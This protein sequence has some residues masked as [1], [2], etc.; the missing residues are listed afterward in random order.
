MY[1]PATTTTTTNNNN[2]IFT[3][4]TNI[5]SRGS[6]CRGATRGHPSVDAKIPVP[7]SM[8]KQQQANESKR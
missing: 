5:R 6:S 7:L 1:I 3:N 2:F 8:N 4:V